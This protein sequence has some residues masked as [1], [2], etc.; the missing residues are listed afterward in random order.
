VV[1]IDLQDTPGG[2]RV[3]VD[4]RDV[5]D[6]IRDPAVSEAASVV[7]TYPGVREAL[8]AHQRRLGADG[9]VVMEGRDI[10]TVVFPDA[11]VKVFLTASVEERARRRYR[12]L[13]DRGVPVSLE[14]VRR[15]E[16]ERDRRDRSRAH[17]PLQP[18]PD[19]VVLD[20]TGVP[21]DEVVRSVLDLC[22]RVM[23]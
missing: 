11:E 1:R 9:G 15:A 13:R 6:V 18:A 16:E 17:S 3:R 20:T 22:R 19:A 2:L 12:E 4:G 14:E 21:V 5:T 10:G 23:R 7:S 8:V